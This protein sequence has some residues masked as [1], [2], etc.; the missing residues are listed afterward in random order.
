MRKY[1]SMRGK[2]LPEGRECEKRARVDLDIGR[3]EV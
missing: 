1:R 2:M 3:M